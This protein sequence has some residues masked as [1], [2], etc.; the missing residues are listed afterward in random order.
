MSL[1]ASTPVRLGNLGFLSVGLIAFALV[2]LQGCGAPL[3]N[4]PQLRRLPT[5]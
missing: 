4:F 2:T 3:A 1:R 5:R